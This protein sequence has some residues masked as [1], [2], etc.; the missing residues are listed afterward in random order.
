MP[1]FSS[2]RAGDKVRQGF[3]EDGAFA[4]FDDGAKGGEE[5]A[6]GEP[7]KRFRGRRIVDN[8]ERQCDDVGLEV[9]Q[10]LPTLMRENGSRCTK[11]EVFLDG[12]DIHAVASG[13]E[14]LSKGT[15]RGCS[16]N[17]N[18]TNGIKYDRP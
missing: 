7:W 2:G 14:A 10:D 3:E 13:F 16:C 18:F 1:R 5:V 8:R 15:H 9:C 17:R 4:H 12:L 11:A 6:A